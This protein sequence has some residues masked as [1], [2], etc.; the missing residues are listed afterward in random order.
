MTTTNTGNALEVSF[1]SSTRTINF[2]TGSNNDV[3]TY[4]FVMIGK[5]GTTFTATKTISL[6]VSAGTCVVSLLKNKNSVADK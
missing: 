5:V 4:T 2:Y 3:G 6:T 1:T